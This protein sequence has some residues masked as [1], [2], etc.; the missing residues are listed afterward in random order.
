MILSEKQIFYFHCYLLTLF[1]KFLRNLMISTFNTYVKKI[2]IYKILR[3]N[4]YNLMLFIKKHSLLLGTEL[5]DIVCSDFSC[6]KYRFTLCY[7]ILSIVHN[8]RLKILICTNEILSIPSLSKI[9]NSATW[10]EREIWDCFGIFFSRHSDLRRILS[11]YG[12]KGHAFRKDFPLIG[13]YEL[14]YTLINKTIEYLVIE[15]PH[16]FKTYL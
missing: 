11:D 9:F 8:F 13:F 12:F 6:N 10:L 3:Q 16:E 14:Q 15:Q 1:P 7:N 5:I 4:L 2:A